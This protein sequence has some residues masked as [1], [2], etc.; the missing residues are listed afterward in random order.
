[1]IPTKQL[2]PER[3]SQHV[4]SGEVQCRLVKEMCFN[5]SI[6]S[7]STSVG[8]ALGRATEIQGLHLMSLHQLTI[9]QGA[10]NRVPCATGVVLAGVRLS[11]EEIGIQ[12]VGSKLATGIHW[13]DG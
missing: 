6:Y 8:L 5:V 1:M 12:V 4:L 7:R 13:E 9:P 2:E 3:A 11:R 10:H